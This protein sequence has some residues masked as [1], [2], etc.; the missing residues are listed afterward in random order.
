MVI[1]VF[2]KHSHIILALT[3]LGLPLIGWLLYRLFTA[4]GF[5]PMDYAVMAAFF[6]ILFARD[7][8]RRKARDERRKR[9]Q[10]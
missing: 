9:M 6:V 4:D 8:L 2:M 5:L 10:R 1:F 7:F 3:F